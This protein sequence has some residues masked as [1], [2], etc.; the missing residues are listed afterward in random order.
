MDSSASQFSG[1]GKVLLQAEVSARHRSALDAQY[2]ALV[3]KRPSGESFIPTENRESHK[4]PILSVFF[5][6]TPVAVG[7]LRTMGFAVG[8]F[9]RGEFGHCAVGERL[10][11]ILVRNGYR[12]GSQA[13]IKPAAAK[14]AP[15][16]PVAAQVPAQVAQSLAELVL[17]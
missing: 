10:F 7:N 13:G 17:A 9:Q 12:L 4:A 8:E 5:T 11:W 3:G 15:A 16:S 2:S 14:A 6:G 1:C